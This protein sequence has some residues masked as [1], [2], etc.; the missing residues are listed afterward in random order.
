MMLHV[1]I[2]GL[3]IRVARGDAVGV[4]ICDLT[5][6][7]RTV[8]PGSLFV[9]R[10]GLK[11]DGRRF[12]LDAARLG[13]AA[14]L[15]DDPEVECPPGV[16]V[17]VS[18]RLAVDCAVIAER[19]YGEPGSR[20]AV[21]GVTG[22]NGKSTIAHLVH[23]LLNRAGVRCG[24]IGTIEVDDGREV[25]PASMTTPP[26][27]EL[28]HTLS[29][30]VEN[31]C[32]AVVMEVSSHAL[33]Q[34]RADGL[35]FDVAVF[36]N[37]THDHRD[38]HPTR[39][40]YLG[41]KRRLFGLLRSN[42]TA[43]VN[44]DDP[45]GEEMILGVVGGSVVRCSAERQADQMVRI[46]QQ[47]LSGMEVE[48]T[49]GGRTLR[50]HGAMCGPYNAM[51]MLQ[52]IVAAEEV[53]G[54]LGVD[55]QSLA[56]GLTCMTTPEGRLMRVSGPEDDVMVFVDYAH[57][58]DA[59]RSVL[60]AVRSAAG[61]RARVCAVI[62]CGG[63]RD[64]EKRPEMGRIASELADRVVVTSDNPRRENP[65]AIVG[66]VIEGIGAADRGRIDVHIDRARA[67]RAAIVD[68]APGEVVVIAG[69]G[70]EKE[71]ILPDPER[72]GHVVLRR[73]VDAE[74]AAAALEARRKGEA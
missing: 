52:A 14:I 70:H 45:A 27:I 29:T 42:G 20:L 71:Q 30:M 53:L 47:S 59:L 40:H 32:R 38:Y 46:A 7:S 63:D 11:N 22:T 50:A 61:H 16:V 68:A 48:C 56:P 49:G 37:L 57:T 1:L 73:F 15:T 24:L 74:H 34:R 6:D 58:P 21:V 10:S 66:Q 2:E 13:A 3:G 67:I 60:G 9:A 35:R 31:G 65:S 12:V 8:M 64:R 33:D 19:F 72:P 39:E 23:R 5:E 18:D 54:R 51:N 36:T 43:V 55:R 4:R 26:A 28:S 25:A 69:K 44:I 41:A 62:G 17:C